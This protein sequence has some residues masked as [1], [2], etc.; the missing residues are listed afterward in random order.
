MDLRSYRFLRWAVQEA[1]SWRGSYVGNPNPVPLMRFDTTV[2][3]ARRAL[4]VAR[5]DIKKSARRPNKRRTK[6]IV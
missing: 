3:E 1:A 4:K 5:D 6:G 2:K